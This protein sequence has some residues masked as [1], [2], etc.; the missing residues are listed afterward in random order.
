MSPYGAYL[1]GLLTVILLVVLFWYLATVSSSVNRVYRN[2]L[3][4]RICTFG[5]G[6]GA[7]PGAPELDAG[8]VPALPPVDFI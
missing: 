4:Y 7:S 6:L 8:D 1:L 5:G 2:S 3:A